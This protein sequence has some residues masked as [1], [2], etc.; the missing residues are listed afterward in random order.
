MIVRAESGAAVVPRGAPTPAR[1]RLDGITLEIVGQRIAE[2][3]ATMEVLLFHSGYSTI[4]RE[5]H[6]GSATILDRDGQDQLPFVEAC[7]CDRVGRS[8]RTD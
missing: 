1:R 5:S 4:L 6:D 2:I 8:G 7:L 3:V